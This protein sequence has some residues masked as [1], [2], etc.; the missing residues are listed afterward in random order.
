MDENYWNE[1]YKYHGK[2]TSLLEHSSFAKFC[3]AE[4]FNQ[5][6]LN[7]VEL[8][9]GNGRDSAFFYMHNHNVIGIDKSEIAINIEKQ[10]MVKS[11]GNSFKLINKNF[12]IEDY[13]SYPPI[14]VFY[15][16][17]TLHSISEIDEDM[18]LN[19]VYKSLNKGG[20]FSIE[21][22]TINDP[23]Y[24]KGKKLEKNAFKTDHYRRFIDSSLFIKKVLSIGFTLKYFNE[25]DNL[26]VYKNDNPVLMRI[27]LEK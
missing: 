25:K 16:R 7:I 18:I 2:D 24:G 27:I 19:K 26:S 17:F 11:S 13:S 3:Q 9:S 4:F 20:L 8:G 23:L 12:I 5:N 21:A 15:S 6:S 22:R 10:N 1:F 14:D